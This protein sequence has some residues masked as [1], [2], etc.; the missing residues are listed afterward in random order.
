[1][2]VTWSLLLQ[3]SP[4]LLASVDFVELPGWSIA[5]FKDRTHAVIVPHSLDIEWSLAHTDVLD[6]GWTARRGFRRLLSR[7]RD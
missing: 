6:A 2:G 5:Q 1:L 4:E 7:Q 3:E